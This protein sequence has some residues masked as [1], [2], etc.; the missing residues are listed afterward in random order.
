MSMYIGAMCVALS[1]NHELLLQ[2][3]H[4]DFV[5]LPTNNETNFNVTPNHSHILNSFWMLLNMR[6]QPPHCCVFPCELPCD[7]N[8]DLGKNVILLGDLKMKENYI[9]I[10]AEVMSNGIRIECEDL[11]ISQ[12]HAQ[13]TMRSARFRRRWKARQWQARLLQNCGIWKRK[14]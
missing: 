6:C 3:W 12:L 9:S 7:L 10:N 4:F 2:C 11:Y 8:I 1:I 14:L 5:K 13:R